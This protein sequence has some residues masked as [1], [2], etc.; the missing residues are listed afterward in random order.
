MERLEPIDTGL[1][2]DPY[3]GLPPV[4][5]TEPPARIGVLRLLLHLVLFALTAVTTAVMGTLLSLPVLDESDPAGALAAGLE[6]LASDRSP[7]LSGLVFAFTLL[8]ILG[9]HELGHYVACRY[10]GIDASLPYFIPAPPPVLIGTFGAFI[11]IRSPFTT[12]RSLFD[13]G[14]AGPIAGFLFALPAAVVG[15]AFAAPADPVTVEGGIVFND[16]LLFILVQKALDLPTTVVWNPIYFAAW[17]GIFATGLNLLPVG[18]L[19]GGHAVYALFGARGH[20]GASIVFFFVLAAL[21]VLS[22]VWFESPSWLLFLVLLA[23]LAFRRHPP[24]LEHES[25]IGL[26]RKLVAIAVL[27]IFA[28]S[29]IPFP[30]TFL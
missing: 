11:R 12:R 13:V 27:V 28:L 18:Q 2:L 7:I 5:R 8:T 26:G 25:D 4:A 6:S 22:V 20:R 29:F 15:L 17:V 30:V 1:P 24:P 9:M 16:P 19:D 23:L 10:Y 3:A 14:V 21:S